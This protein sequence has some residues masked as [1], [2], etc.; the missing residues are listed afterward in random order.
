MQ[1]EDEVTVSDPG[2]TTWSN[3]LGVLFSLSALLLGGLKNPDV[4]FPVAVAV[5][6]ALGAQSSVQPNPPRIL[7]IILGGVRAGG[8]RQGVFIKAMFAVALL[9]SGTYTWLFTSGAAVPS[10]L[11][12]TALGLSS[13]ASELEA[14]SIE[15]ALVDSQR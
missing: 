2:Y 1:H 4:G 14:R 5:V 8:V 7:R 13:V 3:G 6:T 10:L 11:L 15:T 12:G 9:Y